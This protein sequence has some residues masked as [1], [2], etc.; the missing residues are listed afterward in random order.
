MARL[1]R[2]EPKKY[3]KR[4][5]PLVVQ[6]AQWHHTR[7]S[8]LVGFA[9]KRLLRKLGLR[10]KKFHEYLPIDLIRIGAAPDKEFNYDA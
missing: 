8:Q 6:I 5:I 10:H 3:R 9:K 4:K 7:G 2:S 1:A